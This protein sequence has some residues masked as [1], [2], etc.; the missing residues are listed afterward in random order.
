MNINLLSLSFGIIIGAI[1]SFFY[2]FLSDYFF[3]SGKLIKN[4]K[5]IF[6]LDELKKLKDSFSCVY[7]YYFSTCQNSQT[8]FQKIVQ[9]CDQISCDLDDLNDYSSKLNIKY[10][11]KNVEEL[12]RLNRK[13]KNK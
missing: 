7:K 8:E 3:Y 10:I 12:I 1:S 11:S 6:F 13:F 2:I 5:I 4:R 9:D